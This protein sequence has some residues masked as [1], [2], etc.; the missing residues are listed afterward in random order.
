MRLERQESG[1]W[2]GITLLESAGK[3]VW[4]LFDFIENLQFW[5]KDRQGRY[6]WVNR[7]FLLNYSLE[8]RRLVI[9]KTDFDL[10]PRPLADQFQ[11]DDEHVLAGHAI[12]NR[13][14]LVG[15]FDHTACWSLT[16]KIPLCDVA[17]RVVGTAGITRP[18]A[19]RSAER[20]WPN[21]AMGK[22]IAYIREH[23]TESLANATLARIAGQ[24]VRVFERCF[25]QSFHASP[26]QYVKRVRLRM[27]CHTLVYTR[28][29]LAQIAAEHG[30]SDQSHFSR[31]FHRQMGETPRDYRKRYGNPLR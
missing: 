20:D 22:V 16:S 26:Q 1:S 25:R 15:R 7:G 30:F 28:R 19:E 21:V 4:R 10:S 12:V 27:A 5:V 8:D 13:I 6:C 9:G 17:G 14:E 31:E 29:P 18:M 11:I 3:D 2:V 24:S 23:H